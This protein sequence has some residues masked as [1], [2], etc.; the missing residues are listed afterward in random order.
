MS[1]RML[2]LTVALLAPLGGI[3]Q[4]A[5]PAANDVTAAPAQPSLRAAEAPLAG[6]VRVDKNTL[7]LALAKQKL[8]LY[9]F[10]FNGDAVPTDKLHLRQISPGVFE[11]T[12]I[13]YTV[14]EWRVRIRDAADYYGLGERSDRLNHARTVIHNLLQSGYGKN[15]D[16]RGSSTAKPIPFFMSTTGY[17]VW[18]DVTGD[19][20]F[21]LNASSESDIVVDADAEKLRILLFTG[22]EFPKILDAFTAQAGRSVLPPFWAFAPWF[23]GDFQ[24]GAQLQ[25]MAGKARS[26]NL[27]AS[28]ILSGPATLAPV[29]IKH[30][31]DAGFKLIL[32]ETASVDAKSPGYAEAAASGFFV[33]S[34]GGAP[35]VSKTEK[36]AGSFVDFTNPRAKLCWQDQLRAAIQAG[37]DGF[38]TS[39]AEPIFPGDAKFNDESDPRIMRNRYAVLQNNALEELIQKEMKGN[40][41]LLIRDTST[42]AN[43]LGFLLGGGGIAS[44]SPEDGIAAVVTAGLNSG[45][46]GMPLWTADLGGSRASAAPDPALF[47]RW[48]EFAA[49]TPTMETSS[50]WN[51]LPGD[52]GEQALAVYR[53]FSALN[54]SLFPYRYAA[55]QQAAKTGLPILRALVLNYQDDVQARQA[56]FEYL[57]GPD[58]L[59]APIV[60]Q[61]TQRVVYLPQGEWLD[62]WTGKPVA[63]GHAVIADAAIDS[64]PVYVKQ[65]AILPKIPDDVMTFVPAADKGN[66]ALKTLDDRRVY[67]LYGTSPGSPVSITDFEG[68][69]LVRSADSL[70]IT[71]EPAA[72]VILRW[73]FQKVASATVNGSPAEVKADAAGQFIEFEHPKLSSISWR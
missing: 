16:A 14:G 7:A 60:D 12:S 70:S 65:G 30:L 20:T 9:D 69:T 41:T 47:M 42:G 50:D 56:R 68:R 61:G 13:A 17:G 27:P 35:F 24:S 46:S 29:S 38:E 49:F 51:A 43:G 39:D 26:L 48:T 36:S 3:A 59:V 23:G 15:A 71:G 66:K 10:E 1:N 64:T 57:F 19:A 72:H 55:A 21:D 2:L 37:A 73:R 45:L 18:F 40:G 54:M 62:Y 58:L 67:E 33:K 44:F 6:L 31:H 4:S 25:E 28:V 53:K 34:S 32:P 22:P 8:L 5:T 52:W 63:G 11:I